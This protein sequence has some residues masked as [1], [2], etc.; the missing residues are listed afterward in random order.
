M[1]KFKWKNISIKIT[2]LKYFISSKFVGKNGKLKSILNN[3]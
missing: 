3:F 2:H 1:E